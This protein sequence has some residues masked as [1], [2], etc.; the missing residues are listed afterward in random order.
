MFS[1]PIKLN[2]SKLVLISVLSLLASMEN[3]F[4]LQGH[5]SLLLQKAK[6]PREYV[7]K[8]KHELN[9]VI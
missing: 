1:S 4:M 9:S 3:D 5:I 6:T 7:L 8:N 2:E